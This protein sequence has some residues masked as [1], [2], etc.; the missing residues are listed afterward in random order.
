MTLKHLTAEQFEAELEKLDK[1][2]AAK[3]AENT[4]GS[5]VEAVKPFVAGLGR[6]AGEQD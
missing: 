3:P 6:I 1:E 2:E 5:A 4:L